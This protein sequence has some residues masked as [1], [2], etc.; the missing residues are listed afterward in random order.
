MITKQTITGSI[1]AVAPGRMR[2][3]WHPQHKALYITSSQLKE[4]GDVVAERDVMFGMEETV[5]E[6][7]EQE[8]MVEVQMKLLSVSVPY[9]TQRAGY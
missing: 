1:I 9:S 2:N 8:K 7:E 5:E 6:E 4:M 3:V